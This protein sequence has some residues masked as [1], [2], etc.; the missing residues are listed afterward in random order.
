MVCFFV[1]QLNSFTMFVGTTILFYF[2]PPLA[3]YKLFQHSIYP[4]GTNNVLLSLTYSSIYLS[5]PCIYFIIYLSINL[6]TLFLISILYIY[7]VLNIYLSLNVKTPLYDF[8]CFH[9]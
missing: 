4:L 3:L 8:L 2:F 5:S 6:Y 7:L 1:V 9:E